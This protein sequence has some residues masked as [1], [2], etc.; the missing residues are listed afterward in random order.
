MK[1]DV[2]VIGGGTAGC[3]AA[4]TSGKLGLK[5]LLLE[6]GI[7][8][9]GTITSGLVVPVMKSGDNQ[10]NTEFYSTLIEKLN[11][12]GGQITYQDNPGWFN[13]ELTKIILDEMMQEANVDVRFNS[14]IL[15]ISNSTNS[16]NSITINNTLSV[17]NEQIYGDNILQSTGEILSVPIEAKYYIDATGD[18]NFSK[19]INCEFLNDNSEFQPISLRFIMSGINLNIFAKWL[20]ELDTDRDVTT[21]ENINGNIHLS[22]AY[23]WD[24]NKQWA[25]T[26][27]FDDAVKKNILKDTDRNYFQIFT[28]AGAPDSIAFNCPRIIESL[29]PSL[30]QDR[31]TALLEGRQAILR[32]SHF[33]KKYFPGFEN[34]YISNI[35]DMLGVRVSNRIRGKYIYT[36]DDLKSG[37]TFKNP[38]VISNY[39]IDVHSTNKNT[40]TLE[41][42]GEYQLPIESLMS[43]DFENLFVAGRGI[44]A[45]YMSQGALRVQASCFSMGEGAAKYIYNLIN[46]V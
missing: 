7:H 12:I 42:T 20:E 8:L 33:C 14:E 18:L 23:T 11:K 6:K 30:I 37:K 13:H 22:T 45:D 43:N 15:A 9:G 36:I 3:A 19:K 41:K 24:T 2:V 21:I 39:P 5:T 1:Y 46:K 29:N 17:Y 44:S 25:L 16:I 34:S 38:V 40:S 26:P 31:T 28:I 27:L 4:Y 32:L 35:A 10:I